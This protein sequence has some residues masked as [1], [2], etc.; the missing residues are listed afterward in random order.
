MYMPEGLKEEIQRNIL[1]RLKKIEGQVR[2]LQAMVT[3]DRE[4]EE[5]LIQVRAVQSALKSLSSLVLKSYLIK[6]YSEIG[7]KPSPEEM[8]HKLDHT[9]SVLTKFI[10]G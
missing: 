6:C 4:C 2:G 9:V 7:Q 10:G 8:F 1:S 3:G 5:I